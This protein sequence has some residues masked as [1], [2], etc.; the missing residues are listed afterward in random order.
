MAEER[1]QAGLRRSLGFW[2]LV[3]FGVGDILGAGIYALVRDVAGAAGHH[4]WI[5]F[6]VALVVAAVTALSYAEW[7][8]RVPRSAGEA[9]F[10]HAAFRKAWL[11]V[12][13]GWMV[14]FSG[15]VSMATVSRVCANYLAALGIDL[16]VPLV[17]VAFLLVLTAINWRGIRHASWTNVLC[18]AVELT[19]LAIVLVA[20]FLVLGRGEGAPRAAAAA[21]EGLPLDAILTGAAL[22]FFAFIGFE[23]MVNVAEE[24]RE[25]RRTLPRAIL[26][27]I[28][29]AGGLYVLVTWLAVAA[30]GPEALA[31]SKAPL[32]EVVRRGA[33]AVPD[34]V[35]T[36]IAIF[37]V[38]NTAL[39]N[40][41]MGSRLVYGMARYR[42]LPRALGRVHPRHR[43]PY[44]A[45]FAILGLVLAMAILGE[46]VSLA[47]T[48]ST[49]LLLV[50]FT[51]QA[52][53]LVVKARGDPVVGFRV[54][55]VVPVV[56]ALLTLGLVYFMPARSLVAAAVIVGAGLV[57]VVARTLV[58][59]GR[60]PVPPRDPAEPSD[61]R[62]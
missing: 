49:L 7:G 44:V 6:A 20:G 61:P 34:G 33:P 29:L 25:P 18:T 23:D 48:T 51:V 10:L 15:M 45:I 1:P 26:T 30:V 12:L 39:L 28:A 59:R 55:A 62:R 54:P 40:F 24:V 3:A 17:I 19:G 4:A 5:A 31:A 56:G 58:V 36:A 16:P 2:A 32:L 53:L 8:G 42:L 41:V 27:A 46:V 38:A 50:F 37:A 47:G 52:S 43:T 21:T 11:P 22:S 9:A 60:R 35:F 14:L 13:V 57:L